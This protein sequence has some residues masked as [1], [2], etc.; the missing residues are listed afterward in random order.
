MTSEDL[1]T[2]AGFGMRHP[3]RELLTMRIA[4]PALHQAVMAPSA[5]R[6]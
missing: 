5:I 2:P 6:A 3:S 1:A 4:L